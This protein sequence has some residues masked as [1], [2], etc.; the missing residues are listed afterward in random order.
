M[1]RA[2]LRRSLLDLR[3]AID[4]ADAV[5]RDMLRP[6][7]LRELGPALHSRNYREAHEKILSVLAYLMREAEGD[8]PP[9]GGPSTH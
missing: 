9:E 1:D 3:L 2:D 5:S 6:P 8:D 7:R 4:D